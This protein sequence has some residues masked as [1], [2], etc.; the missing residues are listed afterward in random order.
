MFLLSK[1]RFF[2]IK[3]RQEKVDI[4]SEIGFLDPA[5]KKSTVFSIK[6]SLNKLLSEVLF[7]TQLNIYLHINPLCVWETFSIVCISYI[8]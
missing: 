5:I 2:S 6:I 1:Y 7:Y 8:L 3:N 4:L